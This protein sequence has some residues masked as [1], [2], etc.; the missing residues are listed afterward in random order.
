MVNKCSVKKMLL[1]IFHHPIHLHWSYMT[2]IFNQLQVDKLSFFRRCCRRGWSISISIL[3]RLLRRTAIFDRSAGLR[4]VHEHV[5]HVISSNLIQQELVDYCIRLVVHSSKLISVIQ[6]NISFAR[7]RS[8]M[9]FLLT[10]LPL[11]NI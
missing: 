11:F 5:M 2:Q 6:R 1:R 4:G 9:I 7:S 3:S 8:T 10:F